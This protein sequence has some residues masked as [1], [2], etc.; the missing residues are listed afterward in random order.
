MMSMG[1][2]ASELYVSFEGVTSAGDPQE[3]LFRLS[4]PSV[5]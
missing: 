1:S 5:I 3:Q 2:R 4:L